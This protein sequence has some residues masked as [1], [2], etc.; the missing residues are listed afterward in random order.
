MHRQIYM[1]AM[2][3][4]E[5]AVLS[6]L[7][8]GTSA[9]ATYAADFKLVKVNNE[10]VITVSGELLV[11]DDIKFDE[12]IKQLPPHTV[13]A[14]DS[15]GGN[16]VEAIGWGRKAKKVLDCGKPSMQIRLCLRVAGRHETLHG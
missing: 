9:Y 13:V 12:L 16:P 4:V 7:L 1:L 14:F 15:A 2:K 3:F 6:A 8:T 10:V 5:V 11:G